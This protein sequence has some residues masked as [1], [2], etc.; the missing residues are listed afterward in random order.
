[1]LSVQEAG[2]GSPSVWWLTHCVVTHPLCGDSPFV[3]WLT[4]FVVA[5]SLCGGSPSVWWPTL[6]DFPFVLKGN[7]EGVLFCKG[8]TE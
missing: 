2:G 4:P 7:Q 3:W 6:I 8:A 5:H 1:M